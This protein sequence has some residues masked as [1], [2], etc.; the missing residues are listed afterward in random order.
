MIVDGTGINR[1]NFPFIGLKKQGR[2]SGLHSPLNCF[3]DRSK[4]KPLAD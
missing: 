3:L 2:G 4:K 1:D